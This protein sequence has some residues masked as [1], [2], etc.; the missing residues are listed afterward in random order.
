[1]TISSGLSLNIAFLAGFYLRRRQSLDQPAW[2][3]RTQ[4]RESTHL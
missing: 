3:Q 4:R 2:H 1:V